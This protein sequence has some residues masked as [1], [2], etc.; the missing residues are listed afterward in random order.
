M[1]LDLRPVIEATVRATVRATLDEIE[2]ERAKL[3]GQL[4]YDEKRAA[5]LL[6]VPW[7]S[8][9]DARLR[10]EISATKIGRK[11]IYSRESLVKFLERGAGR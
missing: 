1:N 8:L 10:G 11:T 9:R 3:N 4:G 5:A 2:G 6:G 7:Y